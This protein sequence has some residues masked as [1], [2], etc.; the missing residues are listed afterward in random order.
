MKALAEAFPTAEF[1]ETFGCDRARVDTGHLVAFVEAARDA[2]YELFVDLVAVDHLHRRPERFEVVINL[3][4]IAAKARLQ[5]S[6]AAAG[7]PP[8]VPSITGV[9]PGANFYE[10]EAF[11][12]FGIRFAGHPSLTRILLPDDWEGHPLRKDE[13]VGSV[14]IQFKGTDKAI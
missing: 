8:E 3:V 1:S 2:G 11:D 12:L 4:N 13:S 7:D 5:I 9:F 10:R 14:P 6:V